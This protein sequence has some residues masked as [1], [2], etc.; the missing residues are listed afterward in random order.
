MES[1]RVDP[2]IA[3]PKVNDYESF[4]T[5]IRNSGL[6]GL[7]GAGFPTAVKLTMKD[8]SIIRYPHYQ[9]RRVRALYHRG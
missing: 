5:A 3:P 1:R 6:V 2:Q 7:G 9:R 8:L 4:T